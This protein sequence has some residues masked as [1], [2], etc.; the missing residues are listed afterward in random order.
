MRWDADYIQDPAEAKNSIYSKNLTCGASDVES[1]SLS[2]HKPTPYLT[3]SP[4][5]SDEWGN[6]IDYT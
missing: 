5:G 6:A 1:P 4:S 2:N 3:R